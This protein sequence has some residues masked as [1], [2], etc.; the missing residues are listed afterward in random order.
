VDFLVVI[1]EVKFL[2]TIFSSFV[3]FSLDPEGQITYSTPGFNLPSVD[4]NN[5]PGTVH[6]GPATTFVTAPSVSFPGAA[7]QVD[8]YFA[9]GAANVPLAGPQLP[10][11]QF[12]GVYP[13][14][15]Y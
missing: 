1:T 5:F 7:P 14:Q 4:P 6:F 12:G 11:A 9:G 13:G 8:P 10:G 15:P 2:P 3:L